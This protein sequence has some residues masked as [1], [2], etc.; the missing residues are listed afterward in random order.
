MAAAAA[1]EPCPAVNALRLIQHMGLAEILRQLLIL[2]AA[3]HIPQ[4]VAVTAH[5]LMAGIQITIGCHRIILMACTAAGKPLGH[6]RAI[7]QIHVE[8]EEEEPLAF[9]VPLEIK[10][11]QPV[12]LGINLRQHFL[13]QSIR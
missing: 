4:P 5:K 8:V 1:E 10:L 13:C 3:E 6:A 9:P 11:R 2:H 7:G 12:I